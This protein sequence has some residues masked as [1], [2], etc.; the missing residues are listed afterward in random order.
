MRKI[1]IGAVS[2][3]MLLILAAVLRSCTQSEVRSVIVLIGDG[4]GLAELS[5]TDVRSETP[6]FMDRAEII[7]LVRTHSATHRVTDSAAAATAFACGV[8]S[9]NGVIGMDENLNRVESILERA[10]REGLSTG[11]VATYSVTHATP[12]G[13]LAHNPSRNNAEAIA[14]DVVA[15]G[16]DLFIAGGR[17]FFEQR[18][19]SLN[20]SSTLR[21]KGYN[22]VYD[23]DGVKRHSRGRLAAMLGDNALPSML[24]GRGDMLPRSTEKAIE[25]LSTLAGEEGSGFFLMVEGSQIDGMGHANNAEGILTETLDFDQ[26]VQVAFDYADSHPATLVLVFADHETGGLTLPANDKDVEARFSTDNHTGIMV[27]IFAYG[28]GAKEFAGVM[29]NTEIPRRIADLLGI[30]W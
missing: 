5:Y 28:A 3:F 8:K 14:K 11:V 21:S 29:D 19:D 26:A 13:Y 6:L 16:V 4:M 15:S 22:I 18:S 2:M 1:I 7:G 27:P 25:V 10:E 20:L 9:R 17:M 24:E 30:N 23:M 12:A